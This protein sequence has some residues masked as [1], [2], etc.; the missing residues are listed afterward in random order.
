MFEG[1]DK[2][3][4]LMCFIP[5][6]FFN[7]FY[8]SRNKLMRAS[9]ERPQTN[10]SIFNKINLKC[11][12]RSEIKKTIQLLRYMG[13]LQTNINFIRTSIESL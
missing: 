8:V 7:A 1:V 12:G 3:S 4:V 13:N 2:M 6:C 11:K 5:A 10:C 9:K